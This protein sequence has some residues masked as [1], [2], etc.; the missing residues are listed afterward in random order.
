MLNLYK[1]RGETPLQRITRFR[2]EKPEFAK[3]ILSYAGRLDPL[4]EGV[5]PVL[6]GE[7]EN[8]NRKEF[9]HSDKEYEVDILL[10]VETDTGDVMGLVQKIAEVSKSITEKIIDSLGKCIG[11]FAQEYP[12]YSSVSI[13]RKNRKSTHPVL[14]KEVEIYTIDF[15]GKVQYSATDLL[16]FVSES[17]Q[18]VSGDFRQ[19]KIMKVWEEI[20][21]GKDTFVFPVLKIKVSCSSG[22]YMRLLASRIASV[23]AIPAL[24]LTIKR[25]KAGNMSIEQ[26][27]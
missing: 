10:G 21:D 20:L 1:K 23:C 9:L 6:V 12:T 13:S 7:E 18:S 8:K 16:R 14:P 27:M 3:E 25:T 24:V 11:K 5:L 17:V 26:S 2:T 4:A 22:V 15:L 19:G